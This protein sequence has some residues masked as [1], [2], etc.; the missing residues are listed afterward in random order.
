MA[1]IPEI[2][3]DVLIIGGGVSGLWALKTLRKK[4]YSAFLVDKDFIGNT[5]SQSSHALWQLHLGYDQQYYLKQPFSDRLLYQ[6]AHWKP[7]Y[8]HKHAHIGVNYLTSFPQST[9]DESVALKWEEEGLIPNAPA[10]VPAVFE[11]NGLYLPT[12][13]P[14]RPDWMGKDIDVAVRA[15]ECSLPAREALRLFYDD[16]DVQPYLARINDFSLSTEKGPPYEVRLHFPKNHTVPIKA[17]SLVVTAGHYNKE[18]MNL[19]FPEFGDD[20]LPDF[21][22][23]TTCT[24]VLEGPSRRLPQTAFVYLERGLH[25]FFHKRGL[26]TRWLASIKETLPDTASAAGQIW[27]ELIN[28]VPELPERVNNRFRAGIFATNRYWIKDSFFYKRLH[29]KENSQGGIYTLNINY[30]TDAPARIVEFLNDVNF[31]N[32]VDNL[33]R[34]NALWKMHCNTRQDLASSR[35]DDG[36]LRWREFY[37]RY[38]A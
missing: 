32:P 4:G 24:L 13:S 12:L 10:F 8:E 5:Y 14:N 6:A 23:E 29:S 21:R 37:T 9:F 20:A 33:A 27:E 1:K 31:P 7:W 28:V 16:P 18:L 19:C 36:L 2:E 25:V 34:L 15:P 26:R 3:V 35:W 38:L 22:K 30:L 11:D 17:R